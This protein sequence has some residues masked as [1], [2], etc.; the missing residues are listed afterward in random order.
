MPCHALLLLLLATVLLLLPCGTV[1][2]QR[3]HAKLPRVSP[4]TRLVRQRERASV[5]EKWDMECTRPGGPG[6]GGQGSAE[7]R[8]AAQARAEKARAGQGRPGQ[9][10]TGQAAP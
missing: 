9:D 6:A 3:A 5:R 8:S 1:S 4:H 10:R 2:R 7:Q